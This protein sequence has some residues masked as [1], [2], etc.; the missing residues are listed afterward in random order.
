MEGRRLA[1][2]GAAPPA[3]FAA[4]LERPRAVLLWAAAV[5]TAGVWAAT[6]VPL[7]WVPSLELPAITVT[8]AWPGASPRA[9]ERHVTSP[10]E[11]ALQGVPGTAD[12]ESWSREGQAALRLKVSPE[13][14]L[15]LYAAEVSDR[16]AALRGAL[17]ERVVPRL[18]REVPEELRDEQGFM[19]LQIVGSM[20]PQDLRRLAEETVAPRLRSLPG[21]SGLTL[22]GGQERELLVAMDAERLR[23]HGLSVETVRQRLAEALSDRSYGWL[24]SPGA[25]H[26][27][28]APGHTDTDEIRRLSLAGGVPGAG[29]VR[30]QDVATAVLGP[31]PVRSLSRIDGK[32]VVTAIVDRATGTHLLGVADGVRRA[33][34]GLQPELPPG[35]SVLVADDR[36][37]DVR[38]ELRG[39]N[40]QAVL[41]ILAI[42]AVLAL[43]LRGARAAL[44]VIFSAAVSLAVALALLR[45]L[46]L[47]LNVLTLAGLVLLDGLLLDNATVVLEQILA[48]RARDPGA[49]A[50]AVA[51]A[52]G[53]VWLP[54]VGGTATTIAALL[55][56]VYASGE[57]RT[58]FAPFAVLA[59]LTFTVSLLSAALLVPVMGRLLP[60]P[61]LSH[62][63]PSR[64][65][66]WALAPY[67][68]AARYPKLTL[69]GLA[70]L[71]GGVT[72]LFINEVEIG[73]RW[74]FEERPELTVRLRL[75]P[76]SGIEQTDELLRGFESTAL[77]RT[78]VKRTIAR[79]GENAALLR[80]LFHEESLRGE[81]PYVLR[82]ALIAKALQ[83]AGL[84][85]GIHGLV[86]NSFYSGIGNVTGFMVEAYGPNYDEL[87]R[88]AAGFAARLETDP[89]IA[90]VDVNAGRPG[91]PAGREVLRLRWD[92]HATARTGI[93]AAELAS[94][95]RSRLLALTPILYAPIEGSPHTPVR[96][97]IAG[98]ER[99]ELAR[100]LTRPL[101]RIGEGSVR[102][103]D[104]APV[105]IE[106]EPPAIE[107]SGQQYRRLLQVYY[108]GPYKMGEER[109]DREIA[110]SALPP[111]Y[112][113]ER[114]LGGMLDDGSR[115]QLLPLI[116]GAL[117]AILL[118]IAAVLE[119]WR[120]ALRVMA[121]IPLVWAGIAMA[122]VVSGESF[123]EGAF[124]GLVLTL[125]IAANDSILLTDR[126]R[127]LR[128][129][130]PSTPSPRLALL[131]LRDR[132]IPLW[133]TALISMAGMLP[134]LVLPEEGR[135]WTG[136]AITVVGGLF[137]STLLAPAAMV[138]LLSWRRAA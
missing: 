87:H 105:E 26:L 36:S 73:R 81:E 60:A 53:G 113:L 12:V 21:V 136:L 37:E 135:F 54:L 120:L 102:L 127:R 114:P 34:D 68:L 93:A 1:R 129:A 137:S 16:L 88:L 46:G 103:A 124:I 86:Q 49:P 57:L 65:R 125:G 106:R 42:F 89:R 97:V 24:R 91:Q 99:E 67:R 6:Q 95:L 111:G 50:R 77:A 41:G 94:L 10:I 82:E 32:P 130:R 133:T 61:S 29:G 8:A 44:V 96:L 70:L 25:Q 115:R 108:Q 59:G 23:A 31:A 112:R 118:V 63:R 27:L 117:G 47:T 56:L 116:A 40:L 84:D 15:D 52:L 69:A 131:A 109:I 17:P 28:L 43:M 3:W 2:P 62:R 13:R 128:L 132:Q 39:L 98:A 14:P 126:Y 5:L 138:A 104:F 78:C 72:H 80:V 122:F 83:T 90:G 66:R 64:V 85:V 35:V 74:E 121:S 11:R 20:S 45:P 7:E 55:P 38:E 107:R 92:D 100:L 30:L 48:E 33:L 22:E 9:V 4:W 58:L 110:A 119:S 79:V 134:I 123:A 71:L 19:T 101:A 51:R 75:P 76:G 18:T